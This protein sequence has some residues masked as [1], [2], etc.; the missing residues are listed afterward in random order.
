[1]ENK[2]EK[3]QQQ[4]ETVQN[5]EANA[6]ETNTIKQPIVASET[7]SDD[8]KKTKKD[9]N[10][11]P[12]DPLSIGIAF[13]AAMIGFILQFFVGSNSA[14]AHEIFPAILCAIFFGIFAYA[15]RV[16]IMTHYVSNVIPTVIL[17][18]GITFMFTKTTNGIVCFSL[19]SE[20]LA[21]DMVAGGILT[22]VPFLISTFHARKHGQSG[23]GGGDI[24]L[25]ASFGFSL[26]LFRGYCAILIGLA[27]ALLCEG[28]S[29]ALK[30]KNKKS[31]FALVPYLAIGNAIAYFL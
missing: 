12:H 21:F 8:T 11:W 9:Y 23:V 5:S 25:A 13:M 16:D 18:L 30:K 20:A 7:T 10:L 24:L 19:P 29:I 3:K 15:A 4:I 27:L 14:L 31:P 28:L 2:N 26:G 17:L 1:M 6:S 22:V